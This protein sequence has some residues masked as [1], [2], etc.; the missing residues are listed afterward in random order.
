M[1]AKRMVIDCRMLGEGSI[2][3]A[4][5][6][7]RKIVEVAL[8]VKATSVVLA[9]NHPSGLAL[10]SNEDV[11]STQRI[12]TA[13]QAVDVILEDH[14]VF[15]DEKDYTSMTQSGYYRPGMHW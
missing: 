8:S 2:N 5:V 4:G 11:V 7:I 12:A 3:S 6:P 10:P 1:D 15:A 14:L 13:L 9:H